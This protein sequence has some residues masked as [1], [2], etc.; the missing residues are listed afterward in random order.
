MKSLVRVLFVLL[1]F[2][3]NDHLEKSNNSP[4]IDM[5]EDKLIFTAKLIASFTNYSNQNDR[6]YYY[7]VDVK[8]INNTNEE[9]EFYT[10]T[11]GSL[12][13]IITDSKQVN[14]LYHNCSADLATL[15]KLNPRQEYSVDVILLRNKY[16]NGFNTNV[17]FGFIINKPK[18]KFGRKIP[19]TNHEIL[20]ELKLMREKQENV[21]WSDPVSLTATSFNPYE[22]RN[23]INDSTYSMSTRN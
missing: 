2:S 19:T 23:I 22:I 8:L 21:I 11:C 15:I 13:N 16:M 10:F 17:K 6:N 9:C 12:I 18:T 20:S 7:L 1:C 5:K 3:C 14:F 4:K